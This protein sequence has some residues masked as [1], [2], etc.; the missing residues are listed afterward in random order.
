MAIT[1]DGSQST[2]YLVSTIDEIA[3]AFTACR[4]KTTAGTYYVK[5]NADI[6][7]GW[8]ERETLDYSTNTNNII[9]D[10]NLNSK[11]IRNFIC[12]E[13]AFKMDK[14]IFRNGQLYNFYTDSSEEAIWDTIDFVET[15]VSNYIKTLDEPAYDGCRFVRSAVW[16]TVDD[17]NA[18][19][20]VKF[21]EYSVGETGGDNQFEESDSKVTIKNLNS[22][23]FSVFEAADSSSMVVGVDSRYQGEIQNITP[24]T[25]VTYPAWLSS[26]VASENSVFNFEM[27]TY[28]GTIS[29]SS[30]TTVVGA[31][32]TGVINTDLLHDTTH[33]SATMNNLIKVTDTQ[34]HSASELNRLGFEV[35]DIS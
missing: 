24:N 31:S 27:P 11:Y 18:D 8:T 22:T 26:Y 16:G 21:R 2:P 14:D 5:L 19:C 25:I 6:D 9:I 28:S 15:S 33:S 30:T 12:N 3:E 20:Y 4:A 17:C 34:M 10:F 13:C 7:G 29:G 23:E 32:S 35:Y 1:G